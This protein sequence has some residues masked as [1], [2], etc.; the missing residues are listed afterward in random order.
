MRFSD[1]QQMSR[2]GYS[3][4]HILYML[5]EVIRSYQEEQLAPLDIRFLV[6]EDQE[7]HR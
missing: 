5:P 6:V 7:T 3:C 4:D 2:P 1:I